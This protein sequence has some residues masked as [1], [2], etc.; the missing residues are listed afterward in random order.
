MVNSNEPYL[1]ICKNYIY[2]VNLSNLNNNVYKYTN[3][4]V[5]HKPMYTYRSSK[6]LLDGSHL[7]DDGIYC[8]MMNTGDVNSYWAAFCRIFK[9]IYWSLHY[10]N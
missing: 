7:S 6:I 2:P 4:W 3:L 1:N 9:S 5:L 10:F 8:S